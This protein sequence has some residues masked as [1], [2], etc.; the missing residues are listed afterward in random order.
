MLRPEKIVTHVEG[1][2]SLVAEQEDLKN[3]FDE[4]A[5]RQN[6]KH[7]DQV[8]SF[9]LPLIKAHYSAPFRTVID[10]GCGVGM[11][12]K[13]FMDLGYDAYGVDL[14]SSVR[15]W[16]ENRLSKKNFF[17]VDT[18]ILSL[19][20]EDN[21]MD[22]AYSLG[23]IEHVGTTNGHSD[24]REDY[25][26]IR[27]QWLLEVFRVVKPGGCMIIGGPNRNF[28]IDSH[29]PDSRASTFE[30]WLYRK[31]KV[32]IHKIWG[33]HFLWGFKDFD[34]YLEGMPYEIHGLRMK[35]YHKEMRNVPK[36]LRNLFRFYIDNLPGGLLKTG[37]NPWAI[38]FIE[39]KTDK[40]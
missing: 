16:V 31:C 25:R 30:K 15:S 3:V 27:K 18:E 32:S 10:V 23:V 39:K 6:L 8:L 14:V 28:P 1:Y 38:A 34:R 29:G 2:G 24:R 12:V 4:Y 21:S 13:T 33:E 35:N 9:L 40:Q 37:F 11:M 22:I 7:K 36:P 5:I 26:E 20:F 17:V 19:P